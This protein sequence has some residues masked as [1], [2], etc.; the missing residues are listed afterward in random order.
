MKQLSVFVKNEVGSLAEI[1]TALG[2]GGFNIR[3]FAVYDTPDFGI[4]RLIVDRPEEAY[5]YLKEKE[6]FCR[7][8]EVIGL[9]LEDRP[10]VL[11]EILLK[12]RDAGVQVEYMYSIVIREGK[13]PM[14][15]LATAQMD[16]AKEALG[17]CQA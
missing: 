11:N 13:V 5:T 3:A 8:T 7:L 16:K 14:I 9:P 6:F 15:I 4:L 12:L 1:T 10:G 2:H 17:L